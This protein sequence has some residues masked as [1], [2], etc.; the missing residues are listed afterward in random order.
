MAELVPILWSL[1][2]AIRSRPRCGNGGDCARMAVASV[3]PLDGWW[4]WPWWYPKGWQWL[5]EGVEIWK[6]EVLVG[7]SFWS[8]SHHCRINSGGAVGCHCWGVVVVIEMTKGLFLM[9][10]ENPGGD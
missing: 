7:P 4:W 10:L 1:L 2:F 8:L 6:D 3:K 5:L 9:A